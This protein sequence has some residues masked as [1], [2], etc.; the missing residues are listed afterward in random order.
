M[1]VMTATAARTRTTTARTAESRTTG[2][3]K[4]AATRAAGSATAKRG[5]NI[6]G[7]CRADTQCLDAG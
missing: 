6:Q 4:S 3:T 5:A 1:A 2:T 7:E